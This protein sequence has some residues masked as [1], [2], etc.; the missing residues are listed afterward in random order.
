MV[1]K[2]KKCSPGISERGR[3]VWWVSKSVSEVGY[4]GMLKWEPGM[5]M[6]R[7]NTLELDTAYLT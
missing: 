2:Q 1:F 5:K 3:A 6:K 7:L 4:F